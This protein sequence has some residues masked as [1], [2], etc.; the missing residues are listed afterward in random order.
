MLE[1]VIDTFQF[2]KYAV[3]P[4]VQAAVI[5]SASGPA[6]R[7]SDGRERARERVGD[8]GIE[9]PAGVERTLSIGR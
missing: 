5:R 3:P 9:L 4:P 2:G 6:S 8:S 1:S 7:S